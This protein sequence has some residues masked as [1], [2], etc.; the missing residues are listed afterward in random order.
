M[1]LHDS[2]LGVTITEPGGGK[3]RIAPDAAGLPYVSG[4]TL[5][6]KGLVWVYWAPQ[7]WRLEV[8]IPQAVTA[9]VVMPAVCD[10]KRVE[11]VRAAGRVVRSGAGV[12][13]ISKAGEYVF[14]VR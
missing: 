2:L 14:A 13:I 3:I 12:F 5:T 1:W 7:N 8:S 11:V 9:Q 10:G 6:P 4:H